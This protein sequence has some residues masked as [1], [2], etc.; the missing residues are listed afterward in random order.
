L[1]Q[2]VAEAQLVL[3]NLVELGID[4][5]EVTEQLQ[6]DGVES[7]AKSFRELMITLS[8]KMETYAGCDQFLCNN[9]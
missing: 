5:D 9:C 6:R 3:D 7:F 2:N 8:K 4:L 1:E